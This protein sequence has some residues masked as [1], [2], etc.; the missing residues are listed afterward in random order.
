MTSKGFSTQY[1]KF[2][3]ALERI[4]LDPVDLVFVKAELNDVGRQ[5]SR[6]LSQQIVGEVQQSEVVHVF[7]SFRMNLRYFVVNQEQALLSEEDIQTF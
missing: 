2:P 5:V 6:D 1:M 4:F 3:Q 7:E